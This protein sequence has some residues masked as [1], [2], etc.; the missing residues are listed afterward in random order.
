GGWLDRLVGLWASGFVGLFLDAF[1]LEPCLCPCIAQ[2]GARS[3]Q[4]SFVADSE[5]AMCWGRLGG[6]CV[7]ESA[8]MEIF[9]DNGDDQEEHPIL[10]LGLAKANNSRQRWEEVFTRLQPWEAS[11]AMIE[12]CQR[13]LELEDEEEMVTTAGE[14]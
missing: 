10:K 4:V 13:P 11:K 12:E 7:P 14:M 6:E 1:S 2:I 3:V 8:S 5:Y 9:M